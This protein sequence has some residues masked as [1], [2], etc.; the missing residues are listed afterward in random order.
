MLGKNKFLLFAVFASVLFVFPQYV[1][2]A[3]LSFS[4]SATSLSIGQKFTLNVFVSSAD[5]S[6]NA[7]SG[8]ISF[9]SSNLEVLSVSKAGSVLSLWVQEPSFSNQSGSVS[10]EGI[11]LNPGFTGK[12]GRILSVE[13]RAK[14]E[15]SGDI[16]FRSGSVLANDGT[17]T[18]VLTGMGSL[19]FSVV[20]SNEKNLE[21]E[22]PNTPQEVIKPESEPK[23]LVASLPLS[24]S[25]TSPT[26]PNSESWYNNKNPKFVW[27]AAANMTGLRLSYG[28]DSDADPSVLYRVPLIS[29]KQ[30][31]NVPD[32]EYFFN[33]RLQNKAGWGPTAHFGFKIDTSAPLPFDIQWVSD[34]STLAQ[35]LLR[36]MATDTLSG[37]DHLKVKIGDSSE[38]MLA[39]AQDNT[40]AL[41]AQS[42]T[43]TY[44]VVV[45]IYDKAGN[46]TSSTAEMI[47]NWASA[48]VVSVPM[49]MPVIEDDSRLVLKKS[50]SSMRLSDWVHLISLVV[51]LISLLV[52]FMLTFQYKLIVWKRR[53][54]RGLRFHEEIVHDSFSSLKEDVLLHIHLLEQLRSTR[55]LTQNE[56]KLLQHL[57]GKIASAEKSIH[58][59]VKMVEKEVV[60]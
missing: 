48:P 3:N 54:K 35:P 18:N 57:Q 17:G 51:A 46:S 4:S 58:E 40:Y 31:E 6:V 30:L 13:F 44:P 38:I 60:E 41:P 19:K 2:S 28:K 22:S 32:G 15:G 8:N 42:V 43:G 29:E 36:V 55:K 10:F 11:V 9:S 50:E 45:S 16:N 53:F 25:I 39:L 49:P 26:H 12:S 27:R 23:A 21:Q 20:D 52:F 33:A 14:A 59:S 1:F 34:S 37:V 24:P 5:Q 7:V 47:V 56:Q